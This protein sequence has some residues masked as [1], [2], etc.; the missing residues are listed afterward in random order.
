MIIAI[1]GPAGAGK[2][3]VSKALATRLGI[4]FLDTGAM[5]RALTLKAMREQVSLDDV[6][7]LVKLAHNT[8]VML[9]QGDDGIV[10]KLDGEDVSEAIR[11]VE[12]TNNTHYIAREASVREIIV[13]WQRDVG[14]MQS[15]VGEGRDVGSVVFPDA[16]YKFY[17]DATPEERCRRRAK[18]L[19]GKGVVVD[20]VQLLEDIKLR[21]KR[22]RERDASPLVKTDDAIT[23][24]TTGMSVDE[25]VELILKY[26]K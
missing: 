26:L 24:E 16:D 14:E 12:V 4:A 10:V 7:A 9:E 21:D 20:E 18:E 5:Y 17:M 25:V 1:D 19:R 15:L 6:D 2:S 11:A 8:S 3:S 22:D 23:L 13:S